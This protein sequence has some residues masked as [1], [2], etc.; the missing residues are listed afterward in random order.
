KP[1]PISSGSTATGCPAATPTAATTPRT[2]AAMPITGQPSRAIG[3]RLVIQPLRARPET[4][5]RVENGRGCGA[6]GEYGEGPG[7]AGQGG[8]GKPRH[9]GG[10]RPVRRAPPANPPISARGS[11]SER[12]P[13]RLRRPRH[14]VRKVHRV[15]FSLSVP[16]RDEVSAR[17]LLISRA[18]DQTIRGE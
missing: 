7:P 8:R 13:R 17:L 6:S 1:T 12:L 2:P 10:S 4:P 14:D 3:T 15:S 16:S 5:S 11:P 18:V 9:A